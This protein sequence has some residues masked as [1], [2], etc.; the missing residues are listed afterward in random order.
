MGKFELILEPGRQDIVIRREFDAPRDVVFAAFMD[1]KLI[2]NWWGPRRYSTIVDHMEP[3]AG[4]SWRFLN[5]DADGNEFAFHGVFH[6]VNAPESM[7]QT[8][9]FEPFPGHVSLDSATFE[10][11]DGKTLMV[12]TSV[13]QSVEDRDQMA[14]DGM[15]GGVRESYERLDEILA[16]MLARA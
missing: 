11:R 13:F 5:R 15:E 6:A 10:E 7:V 3:V 2:P 1:P 8:F 9:E 16:G 12:S 14:A 4:G